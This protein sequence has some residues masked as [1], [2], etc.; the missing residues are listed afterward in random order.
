M[1]DGTLSGL[2]WG[3]VNLGHVVSKGLEAESKRSSGRN[4]YAGDDSS[5]PSSN[6]YCLSPYNE[7]FN[8]HLNYGSS[9]G[10]DQAMEDSPYLCGI[11]S[12]PVPSFFM[13]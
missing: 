13:S 11:G 12:P 3:S 9:V 5:N 8:K 10:E 2:P 4:T 6:S 7:G 1:G